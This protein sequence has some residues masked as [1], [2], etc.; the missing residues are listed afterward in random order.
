MLRRAE[1]LGSCC[2][3]LSRLLV[4]ICIC[5]TTGVELWAGPSLGLN[6]RHANSCKPTQF[7]RRVVWH[8]CPSIRQAAAG[9]L[10]PNSS[11]SAA[12]TALYF[13]TQLPLCCSFNFNFCNSC[14]IMGAAASREDEAQHRSLYSKVPTVASFTNRTSY[15]VRAEWLDYK[16]RPKVYVVLRPGETYRYRAVDLQ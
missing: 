13:A 7:S 1:L 5:C 16:G 4:S 11:S 15:N 10:Y 2:Y 12:G 8:L 6:V 14:C 3:W 9:D